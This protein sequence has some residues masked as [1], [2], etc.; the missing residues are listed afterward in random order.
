MKSPIISMEERRPKK[1]RQFRSNGKVL[2]TVF[3]DCNGVVHHEF[4]P[5]S[6]RNTTLKLCSNCAKQ[7]VRNAQNYEKT[8][9]A[10]CTMIT[11]QLT[12]RYLCLS[13]WPKTKSYSYSIRILQY[14]PDL[15]SA[16]FFLFPKFK[17]NRCKESVLL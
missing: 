15:A 13:F 3:F 1:A 7:Y 14:P 2:L 9:H 10:F 17:M 11:H 8:N 5:R 12:H 16:D 4:L 6:I